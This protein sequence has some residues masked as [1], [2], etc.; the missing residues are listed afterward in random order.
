MS[1]TAK[2]II[3]ILVGLGVVVVGGVLAIVA[4]IP[5]TRVEGDSPPPTVVD[6]APPAT[7]D[8]PPSTVVEPPPATDL[9]DGKWFGFVT[10]NGDNGPTV[11]T[12]DLAEILTG[13]EARRAAVE[14][15]VI[16]EGEDLPNDFFIHDPDDEIEILTLADDAVIKV[17]SAMTPETYLSIDAATLESLFNGS[18]TGEPVYGISPDVSAPMDI[19]VEDGLIT[20]IE[21][22]YLP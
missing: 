4:L 6:E 12:I 7:E 16:E 15:G 20:S 9:P 1:T 19:T 21:S 14:A 17:L 13:E 3:G 2:W 22:V 18:Y 11:V 10:V 8:T 5:V